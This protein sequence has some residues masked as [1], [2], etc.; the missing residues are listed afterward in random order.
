MKLFVYCPEQYSNQPDSP[1][2]EFALDLSKNSRLPIVSNIETFKHLEKPQ[3]ISVPEKQIYDIEKTVKC[4]FIH[5][6]D[7]TDE[8]CEIQKSIVACFTHED[9]GTYQEAPIIKEK[10]KAKFR[11]RHYKSGE[12]TVIVRDE[13]KEFINDSFRVV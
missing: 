7:I 10:H 12:Y 1:E 3:V 6:I 8:F 2:W 11:V 4:G 13:Q 9:G 5:S